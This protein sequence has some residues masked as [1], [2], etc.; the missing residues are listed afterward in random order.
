MCGNKVGFKLEQFN[1]LG[2]IKDRIAY[3][4]IDGIN[5]KR[6]T[7]KEQIKVCES[8][9]GN[10]GLALHYFCNLKGY[11]FLCLTDETIPYLKLE[12]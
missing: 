7:S 10:L 8:T 4:M 1:R 2:S 6:N 5:E 12:S 9:S 11:Q 3:Y